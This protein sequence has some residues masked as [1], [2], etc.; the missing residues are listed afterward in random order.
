LIKEHSN[1]VGGIIW[2]K[3]LHSSR[4][5]QF[6]C[7]YAIALMCPVPFCKEI[8]SGFFEGAKEIAEMLAYFESHTY[9]GPNSQ[10]QIDL[11]RKVAIAEFTSLDE[12]I[13]QNG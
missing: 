8:F 10:T 9:M 3:Y 5:S 6:Y 1:S 11:A 4:K 12:W 13:K 7:Y 2:K